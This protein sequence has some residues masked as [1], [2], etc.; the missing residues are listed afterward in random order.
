MF[1]FISVISIS[2][3]INLQKFIEIEKTED[4]LTVKQREVLELIKENVKITQKELSEKANL[5][6]AGVKKIMLKLQNM[7]LIERVGAKKN[8]Y[9]T[10]NSRL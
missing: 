3:F 4:N 10:V 5:S 8:G 2:F 1:V 6:L 9:W 7:N